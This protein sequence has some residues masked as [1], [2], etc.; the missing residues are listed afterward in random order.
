MNMKKISRKTYT[1]AKKLAEQF[2]C[3]KDTILRHAVKLFGPGEPRKTRYFDEPQTT[4]ILESIKNPGLSGRQAVSTTTAAVETGLSPDNKR[5]MTV[6]EV[7]HALGVSHETIRANGKLMFPDLFVTGKTTYLNEAHV[8]AIKRRIEGHH[9][10][11][12]SLEVKYARTA[13]EEDLIIQQA[14]TIQQQRIERL[15]SENR[16]LA[17]A[18]GQEVL[19]HKAT[20]HL[21]EEQK[22]GTSM[23]QRIAESAGLVTTDREDMLRLYQREKHPS[24]LC[25]SEYP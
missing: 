6:R 17:A 5:R 21:L 15:Q 16:A 8:T 24:L 1:T 20:K 10:L 9:N 19:D 2:G 13:L 4:A 25:F 7:A 23:Y 3:D 22:L 18:Y 11:P 14:M 12:S